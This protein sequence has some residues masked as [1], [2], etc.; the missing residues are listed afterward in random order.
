MDD[1]IENLLPAELF[2]PDDFHSVEK[3]SGIVGRPKILPELRKKHLSER[4]C[5]GATDAENF[6]YFQSY[7]ARIDEIIR[8]VQDAE[9][10]DNQPS[11][12]V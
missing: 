10:G 4:L 8:S 12:E 1:G 9:V 3:P 7:L 5:S 6:R 2:T 11:G